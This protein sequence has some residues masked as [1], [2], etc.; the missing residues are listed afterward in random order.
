MSTAVSDAIIAA[1]RPGMTLRDLQSIAESAI[2]EEHRPYMQA[3][4]FFGHHI[5]LSVG[6]PALADVTLEPGMIFTVEPW[7]YNH[8]RQISVFVEDDVLVTPTGAEVLTAALPR[9]PA[10]LERLVGTR[11]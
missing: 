7:Y 2:P 6:D 11:R 3:G 4:L 9:A 10:D 8:D 1:T 5:G